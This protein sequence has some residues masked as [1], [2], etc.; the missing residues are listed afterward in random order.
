MLSQYSKLLVNEV[1]ATVPCKYGALL[2]A[3]AG[4]TAAAPPAI[5]PADTT[6]AVESF[7]GLRTWASAEHLPTGWGSG[8]Q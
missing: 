6:I 3:S 7:Y 4:G 1:G 2:L 8:N 5:D